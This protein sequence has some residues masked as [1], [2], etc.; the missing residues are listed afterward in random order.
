MCIPRADL[1]VVGCC[2]QGGGCFKL[3]HMGC[4]WLLPPQATGL[5]SSL[6]QWVNLHG[7]APGSVE[8]HYAMPS[9]LRQNCTSI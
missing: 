3:M 6:S 5:L 4:D 2:G 8:A 1:H 9:T 7:I